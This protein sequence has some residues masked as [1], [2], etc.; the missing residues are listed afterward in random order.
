MC[1][2][3]SPIFRQMFRS[4]SRGVII[5]QF[6]HARFSYQLASQYGNEDFDIPNIPIE[7]FLAGVLFHYRG[8]GIVD[9]YEIGQMSED[10]HVDV[11]AKGGLEQ[12]SDP[13]ADIVAR[14]HIR[15]LLG[16]NNTARRNEIGIKLDQ[17]NNEVLADHNL[18]R[19][20]FKRADRITNL[21]DFTSFDF[22]NEVFNEKELL[23]YPKNDS[24]N[25]I[26]V[27]HR[28]ISMNEIVVAPWPFKVEIIT[29]EILGFKISDY[30]TKLDPV[31]IPFVVRSDGS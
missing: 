22:C 17:L 10:I 4:K 9:E 12:C 31:L 11:L 6:E 5:T 1:S 15:R 24:T 16:N 14:F 2:R 19:E 23:V 7:S 28:V 8:Y 26:G 21:F 3:S 13:V 27:N 30:P 20:L 29:G 25:E 18:D